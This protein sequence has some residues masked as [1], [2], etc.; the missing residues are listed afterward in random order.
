MRK[1]AIAIIIAIIITVFAFFAPSTNQIQSSPQN[2]SV[3]SESEIVSI[4]PDLPLHYKKIRRKRFILYLKRVS[5]TT[6]NAN[7]LDK[8]LFFKHSR[9][10]ICFNNQ[11]IY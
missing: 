1:I 7:T 2:S 11:K 5:R 4:Q 10:C 6:Q 3:Y 9:K 8:E